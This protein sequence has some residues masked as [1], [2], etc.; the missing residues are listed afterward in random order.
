MMDTQE[1]TLTLHLSREY[2]VSKKQISDM[3]QGVDYGMSVD[4]SRAV[5]CANWT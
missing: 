3:L 2:G 5:F 4:S 1:P